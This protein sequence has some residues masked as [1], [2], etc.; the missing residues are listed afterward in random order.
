MKNNT[1]GFTLVELM[2]VIAV[3]AI[4]LGIAVPS[5]KR[6]IQEQQLLSALRELR[7]SLMIARSE[8]IKRQLPVLADNQDGNWAT[9][10]MIYADNNGNGAWD[11]G[12]AVVW[13]RG[14]MAAE[15]AI[16]GNTPVRRYVRYVP[17]G[18]TQLL[19][20]AFQ[21][22]TIRLCQRNS[23]LSTRLLVISATGRARLMRDENGSC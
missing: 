6:F 21:A 22:G 11:H 18:Q 14:A 1:E 20:G 10:W 13:Q 23:N 4:L 7:A 16:S 3:L 5:L 17:N 15:L 8:S 12:E 2:V 9:G 19:G